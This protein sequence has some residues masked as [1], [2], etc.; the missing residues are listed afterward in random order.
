MPSPRDSPV[1]CVA[2]Y[3]SS[4]CRWRRNADRRDRESVRSPRL[5]MVG[6][7][8]GAVTEQYEVETD[9]EGTLSH[10]AAGKSTRTVM[11]RISRGLHDW[12]WRPLVS[13]QAY[14]LYR[15]K[16]SFQL[17]HSPRLGALRC[18]AVHD[19]VSVV[20]PVYNGA[21]YVRESIDSVLGQTYTDFELIVIDDGST[22][23]TPAILDE[24]TRRDTRVRVIRQSNHRLPHALSHGFRVA[25]G[26]FLTW[27][28]ADNR[29]KPRCLEKLVDCLRRHPDWDM[30]FANLDIIGDD[31][32]PLRNSSW[33][34]G[35]QTPP[36]SEHIALPTDA[37]EL[38]VVANNTVGAAFLYR[39][40]V[41]FLLGDYSRFRFGTEDYDYWMQVN[42]LFTLRHAD[43]AEPL[44]DVRF[45]SASLTAR[46]DELGITRSREGLM[47][48]D[49]ARRD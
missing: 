9:S 33:Y 43:F 6:N 5:G 47:V 41:D 22:D 46:D 4:A 37:L 48:F 8:A 35:Y 24:Y 25:R 14:A 12:R 29:L 17:R 23:A 13:W 42:S 1:P 44:Y 28:S 18:P 30:V 26:E 34:S 10:R 49:D 36:G 21:D 16:R 38:N 39:N 20:L 19:L 11:R 2:R 45:H 15:F 3:Q 32:K 7:R 27:T 40:Q 31:G